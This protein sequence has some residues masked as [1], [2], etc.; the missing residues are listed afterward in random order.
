MSYLLSKSLVK[1]KTTKADVKR[2]YALH[3]SLVSIN[4]QC[5]SNDKLK[6]MLLDAAKSHF[7]LKCN[8]GIKFISFLVSRD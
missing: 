6:Q 5:S 2:V 4:L 1:S 8:E 7:Y 3:M